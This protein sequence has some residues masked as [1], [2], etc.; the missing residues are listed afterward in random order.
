MRFWRGLPALGSRLSAMG[1]HAE[2][3]STAEA[4]R[5]FRPLVRNPGLLSEQ[6]TA[7]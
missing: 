2:T 1:F 5:G 6:L 7:G 3:P 4:R